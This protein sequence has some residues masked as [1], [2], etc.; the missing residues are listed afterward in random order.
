MHLSSGACIQKTR[1]ILTFPSKEKGERGL[2]AEFSAFACPSTGGTNPSPN[3][4]L[5]YFPY[6]M[7]KMGTWSLLVLAVSSSGTGGS[8]G[9]VQLACF[10]LL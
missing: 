1:T 2:Q 3:K 8:Y 5:G 10:P 6:F 4:G 9:L 7:Q